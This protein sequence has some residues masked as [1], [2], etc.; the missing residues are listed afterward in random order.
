MIALVVI[1]AR[2]GLYRV[3]RFFD[4]F[5]VSKG[6]LCNLLGLPK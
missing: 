1:L 4:Q 3:T 5:Y 6:T 2:G